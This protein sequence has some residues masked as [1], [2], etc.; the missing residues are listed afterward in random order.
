MFAMGKNDTPSTYPSKDKVDKTKSKTGD[1][2]VTLAGSSL[3]ED[4]GAVKGCCMLDSFAAM[5]MT[6]VVRRT[7]DVDS[8]LH[9]SA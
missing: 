7:D 8:A 5:S 3:S 4:R 9:R 1:E 2:G 6:Q